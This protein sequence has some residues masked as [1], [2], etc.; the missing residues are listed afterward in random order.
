MKIIRGTLFGGI[1]YFFLGWLVWGILLMDFMQAGMNQCASRPD[2]EM[3]WWALIVS[4]LAASM[5]LTI[6]LK[7]SGTKG[8][9]GGLST[10]ALFGL[11]YSIMIDLSFWSMTTLYNNIQPLVVDILAGTV[12][13]AVVGVVI[14]LTWGRK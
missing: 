8:I 4:N 7:W 13:F 6:I 9:V 5:L 1:A 2:G 3:V 11:L 10:G 14:M 12:V